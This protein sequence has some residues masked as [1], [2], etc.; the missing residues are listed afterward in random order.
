MN[1]L[2]YLINYSQFFELDTIIHTSLRYVGWLFIR[3]LVGLVDETQ[4]VVLEVLDFSTIMNSEDIKSLL[5][6][7]S[8]AA[9]G[10]AAAALTVYFIRYI[11]SD[12]LKVKTMFDSFLLGLGTM[13]LGSIVIGNL[14]TASVDVARHLY[15]THGTADNYAMSIINSN[16]V[17]LYTLFGTGFDPVSSRTK[18]TRDTVHYFDVNETL[19]KDRVEDEVLKNTLSKK[20]ILNASGGIELDEVNKFLWIGIPQNYYRYHINMAPIMAF[21][22]V[23]NIVY[24]LSAFKFVQLIYEILFNQTI[25][26]L[27]SFLELNGASSLKKILN[28][29]KN[30]IFAIILG[31]LVLK[32]YTYIQIFITTKQFSP[33]T[34]FIIQ[35]AIGLAVIDGP[36]IVQKLTGYDA[37]FKS[38]TAAFFGAGYT[39]AKGAGAVINAGKWAGG[40]IKSRM[41]GKNSGAT[42]AATTQPG[43]TQTSANDRAASISQQMGQ[44]AF[45][46]ASQNQNATTTSNNLGAQSSRTM[47]GEDKGIQNNKTP[48][49]S[50]TTD[51]SDTTMRDRSVDTH[52]GYQSSI[53]QAQSKQ[54]RPAN[55]QNNASH[56]SQS[57]SFQTPS[58]SQSQNLGQSKMG[59]STMGYHPNEQNDTPQ[60]GANATSSEQSGNKLGQSIRNQPLDIG[61]KQDAP[62]E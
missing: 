1:E 2:D 28:N 39:A 56:T 6:T 55:A 27:Y 47:Q 48:G 51:K 60:R 30:A 17:D 40:K 53:E 19:K 50:T 44:P 31:A 21:L 22:I 35:L 32:T 52:K 37:G 59:K 46:P 62:K 61:N 7:F 38:A 12:K 5:N 42:S 29:I 4:K 3:G 58:T 16:T 24:V 45:H 43:S 13:L 14:L 10:I 11:M 49:V 18:L 15:D 33:V 57:P 20:V 8:G 25:L 36:N 34:S 26:P 9:Y 41:Q 54:N 23:V